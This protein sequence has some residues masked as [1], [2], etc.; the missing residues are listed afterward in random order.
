MKKLFV[1]FAMMAT[2]V[3]A[4]AGNDI[5]TEYRTALVMV[6]SPVNN[7][8]EDDNIILTFY[9]ETLWI[10]NKTSRTIYINMSQCFQNHNGRSYPIMDLSEDKR[11]Q[12]GKKH[13]DGMASQVN[14][15]TSIETYLSVAP[16]TGTRQ[17]VTGLFALSNNLYG[18]YSTSETTDREF[19]EFE[20]RLLTLI[21]EML[22]E[23][24]GAD[25]KGKE[26]VGTAYR[27]LT[28]DESVNCIGASIAYSFNKNSEDWTPVTLSTWVSDLYLVPYYVEM[29][30]ELTK[31]DKHGFA[32]KNTE[33]A[34][35]H[36]KANSPFEFDEDKSPV[37]VFDWK[38]NFKKGKFT[39]SGTR[40]SKTKGKVW[41]WIGLGL[42]GGVG[43][44]SAVALMDAFK[45]DFYKSVIHFDG[46][47]DNWGK[48]SYMDNKDLSK[49][50]Y[51]R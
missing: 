44:Y 23:S 38:G 37:I 46:E 15:S 41:K 1:L 34:I 26:Y 42:F 11:K 33:A 50:E 36:I 45:T 21:N 43:L 40:I 51:K 14:L 22:N 4:W 47:S 39:L 7:V 8:Y 13:D 24:L 32:I 18:V 25:P 6:Y 17:N 28:E 27:H 48:M 29:P 30:P 35:V 10:Q 19:T 16:F 5:K 3:T 12:N 9:D 2:A 49:F 31:K 20:E